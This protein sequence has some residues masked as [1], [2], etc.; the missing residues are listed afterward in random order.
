MLSSGLEGK[1]KLWKYHQGNLSFLKEH[2]LEMK[3]NA[4]DYLTRQSGKVQVIDVFAGGVPKCETHAA[5]EKF[6]FEIE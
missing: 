1:I 4:F 2:S 3:I 5:F 6:S